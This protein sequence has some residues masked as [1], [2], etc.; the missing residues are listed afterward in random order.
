MRPTVSQKGAA[1]YESLWQ[2]QS[3]NIRAISRNRAEQ[4]GYYR[5]LENEN[6]RVGELVRSVS[7][8]CEQ[9]EEGL[10]VL[11][12]SDSS[13]L[14][15]QAHVGRINPEGL[16]V[17][18]NNRDKGFFI[19]PTL[20]VN[21]ETGFP[22][23]LSTIQL[24]HRNL[25]HPDK[26]QR[27]YPNLPIE[28]K[29]SYKWLLSAERSEPCLQ[30]GGVRLITHIGDRESDVY[31]EW[32]RVPNAQTHVLVRVCR[33]RRL[34]GTEQSLYE[35]L[36][37][38]PCEGTYTVQVLADPRTGRTAR[39]AWLAVRMT[40]VQ[41]QRPK[42]VSAKDYPDKVQLYAV[43]AKEVNPPAGQEPIHWRLLTTHRVTSLEQALQVIEWYR[44]RWRI[45]QLFAILKQ[46]GLDLES[47]QLESVAAIE[48]LTILALSV[49]LRIL[50]L[51]EGRDELTVAAQVAF[52]LQEQQ[53]LTDLAPSLQG[54]THKQ[55]N[56]YPPASLPWATWL[57]A[58][59]GGWSGYRSQS[60]PGIPTLVRGLRQF[61][62][63]FR[64][65][66]LAQT[67][68]VCTR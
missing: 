6:V 24:W 3:V 27:R 30:A 52:N 57:I 12:I 32:V 4:V 60:P 67:P 28:E 29:E 13:E 17:V 2:H 51:L 43:E 61:E 45:E 40:P 39:E 38:Q 20:V 9:Q 34:W 65:W 63:I 64:G 14:N 10:H 26:H 7:D 44:W 15:L 50:Q 47:T 35:C 1:L 22:L 53:C 49:A 68:L 46:A 48:R 21:A 56:P 23:G 25:N 62:S 42:K 11:A 54:H 33:D 36:S 58:R 19:H 31:E 5:F 66:R 41:I 59:L 16:G 37:Q 55:Q 8:A 18:G